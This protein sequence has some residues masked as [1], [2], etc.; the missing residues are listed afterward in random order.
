MHISFKGKTICFLVDIVGSLFSAINFLLFSSSWYDLY[1]HL[2][3]PQWRVFCVPVFREKG[4]GKKLNPYGKGLFLQGYERYS[5]NE[6]VGYSMNDT[7]HSTICGKDK[8]SWQPYGLK[9]IGITPTQISWSSIETGQRIGVI[10]AQ[11]F[12]AHRMWHFVH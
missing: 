1:F 3:L 4:W 5:L 7:P 11:I 10:S 6:T 2:F 12:L 8:F 9:H